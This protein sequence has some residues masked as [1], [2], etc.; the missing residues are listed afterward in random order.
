[1]MSSRIL[2]TLAL[3]YT[4]RRESQV[5]Q[6]TVADD[7][8]V[9]YLGAEDRLG[10]PQPDDWSSLLVRQGMSCRSG[11]GR[12]GWRFLSSPAFQLPNRFKDDLGRYACTTTRALVRW[13]G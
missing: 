6:V 9:P 1:M 8:K 7:L 11:Y 4:L 12:A 10:S 5:Q 13:W 3:A 2:L